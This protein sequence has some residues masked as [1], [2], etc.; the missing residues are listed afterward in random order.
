[1]SPSGC[2]RSSWALASDVKKLDGNLAIFESARSGHEIAGGGGA[3]TEQPIRLSPEVSDALVEL[4]RDVEGSLLAAAGVPAA[5]VGLSGAGASDR[6]E[7]TRSWQ[8]SHVRPLLR[9]IAAEL[10]RVLG[11]DITFQEASDS[12]ADLVSRSRAA[13][14]LRKAGVGLADALRIVGL[15]DDVELA[16]EPSPDA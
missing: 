4:R 8:L 15:P 14:S 16:P 2:G 1:M 10:S 12:P 11:A 9:L 5:L 13:G 7:L 3:A 6:R